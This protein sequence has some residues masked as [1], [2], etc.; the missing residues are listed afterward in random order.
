MRNSGYVMIGGTS[1]DD[2]VGEA[3]SGSDSVCVEGFIVGSSV[4]VD[5]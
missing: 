5:A 2:C 4:V 3:G 1:L